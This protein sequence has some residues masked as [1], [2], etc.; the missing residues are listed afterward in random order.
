MKSG[1][2]FCVLWIPIL[3]ASHPQRAYES[4]SSRIYDPMV[5]Y[6][7]V[8]EKRLGSH[9]SKKGHSIQKTM[10]KEYAAPDELEARVFRLE[11]ENRKLKEKILRLEARLDCVDRA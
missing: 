1:I 9:R 6:V 4:H 11:Q 10:I 2:A 7:D 8:R 3:Q 5:T